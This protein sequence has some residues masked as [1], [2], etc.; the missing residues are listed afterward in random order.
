MAIVIPLKSVFDNKGV[1]DASSSLKKFAKIAVA[2]VGLGQVG[3]FLGDS[4]KAAV[5]DAKSQALLSN[6]LKNTVGATKSVVAGVETHIS[7]MERMSSVADDKIR[8]AFAQLTRATGNVKDATKL[9]T[10]ALN[11]SAG[12]G[13]DLGAVSVALGKAYNGQTTALKKLGVPMSDSMKHAE[14]FG[15][16]QKELNKLQTEAGSTTGKKHAEIL[17]KVSDKQKELNAIAASGI[18]WQKDLAKAFKGSAET[19]AKAD[20]YQQLSLA[21]DNIKE[22]VGSALL[23]ILQQ[24]AQWLVGVVPSIQAFF[25]QMTDPTTQMGSAWKTVS[26]VLSA[27]FSFI[28]NNIQPIGAF[29]GVILAVKGAVELW[30]F[31]QAVLNAILALNPITL[32]VLAIA[33]LVAAIVWIAT[34]TNWF[35]DAWTTMTKVISDVWNGFVGFFQ[36]TTKALG[37]FFSSAWDS[38]TT[39]FTAVFD[40][41]SGLFKGYVNF[42]LGL[43]ESFI[44]FFSDGINNALGG[45][46]AALD[47]IKT[48]TGGTIDVKVARMAHVSLPRLANGGIVP[49]TVGG[50]QVTVGEGGQ[51]EAIIPLSKMSDMFALPRNSQSNAPAQYNVTVNA[52]MGADGASIG[53]QLVT[54]LKKY[55]RTN[56][57]IWK[58]A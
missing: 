55:E 50:R 15:K 7:A 53:K 52:G 6:Q 25:K 13:K 48:V 57:A 26:D 54:V 2:A 19:A 12:T 42:W 37:G 36:D 45:I 40:G 3:A 51:S 33:A 58:S 27:V 23:P 14:A 10:L 34:K 22:S 29:V 16:A 24:F 1:E 32:V 28:V 35:Q 8:P 46:N 31:A 41:I 56:G 43:F 11:I 21:M 39:A 4:A 5:E 9:S 38:V 44:N 49:A 30:S 47:G 20:P 18:D 17:G